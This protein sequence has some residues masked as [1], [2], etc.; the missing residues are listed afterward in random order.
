MSIMSVSRAMSF[1]EARACVVAGYLRAIARLL[2]MFPVL[3]IE[4]KLAEP[5]ATGMTFVGVS[6]AREAWCGGTPA[7]NGSSDSG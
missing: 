5:L 2:A 7:N 6:L 4:A 1:V 3:G